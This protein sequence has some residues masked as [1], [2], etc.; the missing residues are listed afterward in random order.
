MEG[1]VSIPALSELLSLPRIG[2]GLR[3]LSEKLPPAAFKAQLLEYYQSANTALP[4][5]QPQEQFDQ[6]LSS[7]IIDLP[8]DD[9][10]KVSLLFCIQLQRCPLPALRGAA[11]A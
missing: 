7:Q 5:N 8:V 3:R 1:P 2:A 9:P 11:L 6:V 4:E 10:I